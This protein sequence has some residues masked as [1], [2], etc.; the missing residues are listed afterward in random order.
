MELITVEKARQMR[1]AALEK[2]KT[3]RFE[4]AKKYDYFNTVMEEIAA[5]A[6]RGNTKVELFPHESDYYDEIIQSGKL[7]QAEEKDFSNQQ[8][9]VFEAIEESLGYK[10]VCNSNYQATFF[11][12]IDRI[13]I[14]ISRYSIYW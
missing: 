13:D 12:G 11:R 3:E 5:A 10:V 7:V 2:K 8:K 1:N 9:E 14:T 4:R 6:N